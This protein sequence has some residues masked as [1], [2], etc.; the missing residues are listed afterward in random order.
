MYIGDHAKRDQLLRE[1]AD[2]IGDH[3]SFLMMNKRFVI[4][5]IALVDSADIVEGV[6]L[7]WQIAYVAVDSKSPAAGGQ[8]FLVA[9]LVAVYAADVL[10]QDRLVLRTAYLAEDLQGRLV[11]LERVSMLPVVQVH[12]S[13]VVQ[14]L[15]F[16]APVT[17]VT[18]ERERIPQV[19]LSLGV[20]PKMPAGD[21]GV[22]QGA[23]H[24]AR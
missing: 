4:A 19:S 10:V 2:L 14:H 18:I 12:T 3:P 22:T 9:P 6:C 17:D 11:R 1:V 13:Q 23:S 7:I 20:S 15:R 16:P 8:C 5:C 24:P 21:S